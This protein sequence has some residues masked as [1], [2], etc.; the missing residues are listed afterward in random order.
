MNHSNHPTLQRLLQPDRKAHPVVE[1]VAKVAYPLGDSEQRTEFGAL[2]WKR[3][4]RRAGLS[5]YT[6]RA[7]TAS[8]NRGG[9]Q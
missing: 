9:R 8:C 3:L 6:N 1:C 5:P 7:H 2:L 4:I